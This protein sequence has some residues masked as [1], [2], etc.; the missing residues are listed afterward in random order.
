MHKVMIKKEGLLNNMNVGR[1]KNEV[2]REN[3]EI[4]LKGP[5]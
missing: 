2:D 1:K 4:V 5:G 3:F